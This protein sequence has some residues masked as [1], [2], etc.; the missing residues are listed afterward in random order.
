MN[1]TRVPKNYENTARLFDSYVSSME[2][3]K[4]AE[5]P[6][7]LGFFEVAEGFRERFLRALDLETDK[8]GVLEKLRAKYGLDVVSLV[9]R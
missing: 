1:R 9:L 5:N 3:F 8:E 7:E 6:G 4:T 2:V